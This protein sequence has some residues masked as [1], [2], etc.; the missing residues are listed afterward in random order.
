MIWRK[1]SNELELLDLG[2]TYYSCNEYLDCLN[3]L[4]LVGE[5][6]GGDRATF[7]AIKKIPVF[8]CSILDVGCGGG[9]FTQK[10]GMLYKETNVMGID[11]SCEAI[12]YAEEQNKLSNV[13]F[14]RLSLSEIPSK[15]CDIVISTL[16][17]HHLPDEDLIPFLKDALRVAKSKVI[18]NDL[19]RHPLAWLGFALIAPLLF[20]NRLITHDGCISIKRAFK[21]SDWNRYEKELGIQACLSWHWPFRWIATFE[22]G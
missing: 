3:K 8:P 14:K 19:H 18:I 5:Y 16:V 10:L 20:K 7:K 21:R 6:L 11:I 22:V 1:R 13:S 2:A 15:S 12:K 9:G 17:C 4:D